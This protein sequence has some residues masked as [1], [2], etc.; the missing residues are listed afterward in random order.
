MKRIIPYCNKEFIHI[1]RDRKTL[2]FLLL[3]PIMEVI[4][5]GYAI[6][7]E[8]NN[9]SLSILDNANNLYSRQLI[10]KYSNNDCFRLCEILKDR[11]DVESCL[12]KGSTQIVVIIPANFQK[13]SSNS[14]T[15]EKVQFL[16]DSS[17]PNEGLVISNYANQILNEYLNNTHSLI[18]LNTKH[19]FNPYQKSSYNFVPGIIGLVLTLICTMMTSISITREKELGTM[20]LIVLSSSKPHIMIIGKII[21][22]FAI[23]IFNIITIL[24]ISYYLLD[25]PM[26]GSLFSIGLLNMIFIISTIS[27]GLFISAITKTQQAAMLL[28]GIGLM[29]PT[30]LLSGLIFPIEN[31]PLF[32]RVISNVFPAKWFISALKDLMIRGAELNAVFREMII[33]LIIILVLTI[34]GVKKMK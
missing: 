24:V 14:S 1:W 11:D 17:N 21:P 2:L 34:I 32:L 4:I 8:V 12:R 23:G 31:M 22:Y 13:K 20:K 26:K 25:V 30:I 15:L 18:R 9:I 6:T 29:L 33:L 3:V 16:I 19:F 27:I 5:F 28:S 10:E 7:T